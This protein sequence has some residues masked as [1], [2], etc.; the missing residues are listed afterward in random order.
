M[1]NLPE[2]HQVN[3]IPI[4]DLL[5]H[6]RKYMDKAEKELEESLMEANEADSST[7]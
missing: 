2:G 1:E 7:A 4:K 6:Y 5:A 3:L